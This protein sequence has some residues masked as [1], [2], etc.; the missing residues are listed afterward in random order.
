MGAITSNR[1]RDSFLFSDSPDFHH[2][3]KKLRF[4]LMRQTSYKTP[5]SSNSTVSRISRY[6]ESTAKFRREVHAPCRKLKFG[7]SRPRT[8][9]HSDAERS[10][11]DD[12]GHFLSKK[13]DF[14]K[15]KAIGAFRYLVKE[16]EVVDVD[17][18]APKP[19]KEVLTEDSSIEE[20][21]VIEESGRKGRFRPVDGVD[22]DVKG[23]EERSVVTMNGNMEVEN[24]RNFTGLSVS[25]RE[26]EVSSVGVYKKLLESV[27]RSTRLLYL[28][29]EIKLNEERWSL[30]K[31]LRPVKKPDEKLV[32]EIPHEPFTA[33]T[34]EEEE[35]VKHALSAGN[36]RR[37]LVTHDNSNI[38]ITG[39]IL[40]C[41]A[42]CT[43]LNDEVINVYLELLKEREKREPNKF[44]KCH[45]FNTFFYKKLTCG[46]KTYDYKAV[47]R[48]TTQWKL[49]Y[50]L[51]DCDKI[52]VPV[53]R[54][55]HWCLA[56]INNKDRKFQY[57]DSMKGTDSRVLEHLAR[58]YVEEVKDKS[59][60]NIDVSSWEREFL[61]D[62]PEQE[63]WHDCGMFMIKYADF[64]SRGLGLCFG[65]EHMPYF[66]QRTA[67]EILR[68]R[69][70]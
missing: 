39:E 6:P 61:E 60:E 23:A 64:Y 32:E 40:Q 13:L 25:D 29:F 9:D 49:G 55:I 70:D 10:S 34:K 54:E 68:L 38:D 14:A 11:G 44:L 45:F 35:E 62:L 20:I 31:L 22:N 21:E 15:R 2:V 51:V 12:M 8:S 52:F 69:A 48:W 1:K 36:R 26:V 24:D 41:L 27:R 59:Q 4:S 7:L 5:S 16:K 57:L 47:K 30:L 19:G 65:Q 67:K 56:I 17:Y 37:L 3:Q 18:E 33:L 63:N 66:R 28:A 50:F 43:W 46:G 53:H 42:P 58:Y